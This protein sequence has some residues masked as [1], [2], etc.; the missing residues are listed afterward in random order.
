MKKTRTSP[1]AVQKC[2]F[3]SP[4]ALSTFRTPSI[5]SMDW[6]ALPQQDVN[7]M[8]GKLNGAAEAELIQGDAIFLQ[9]TCK[10]YHGFLLH[11]CLFMIIVS[12]DGERNQWINW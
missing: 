10:S 3:F 7:I 4:V 6:I 5:L 9:V 8:L 11:V 2:S 12:I 1:H